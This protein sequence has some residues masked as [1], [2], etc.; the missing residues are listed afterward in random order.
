MVKP[1]GLT[2][3]PGPFKA[4]LK[5]CTYFP[6]VP[7]FGLGAMLKAHGESA[8]V[9]IRAAAQ[10]GLLLPLGLFAS[11][12]QEALVRKAG[13]KGFGRR[14]DLL[15]PF[16]DTNV[17]ACSMW[18]E[19]PGVCATYF[20]KS[21]R[22]GEGLEFWSDVEGYLNHFEWTLANAAVWSLGFTE[23]DLE[24]CEHVMLTEEPGPE[25]D[26]LVRQAWAEWAGREEEFYLQC[27]ERA[28]QVPPEELSELLGDEALE[29]EVSLRSRTP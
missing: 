13:P 24:K 19:R 11:P 14:R 12:E 3:D 7:N 27:L 2:R 1:I 17:N 18:R 25:R 4:E 20:C 21:E 23:D 5:C 26:F 6:F 8:R 15:C 16:Y 22:E 10:K 29:L 28:L 9:R